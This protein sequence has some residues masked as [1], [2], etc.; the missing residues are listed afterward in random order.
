MSRRS[1][2]AVTALAAVALMLAGCATSPVAN[3]EIA[4]RQSLPD[5]WQEAQHLP[6]LI[7][8]PDPVLTELFARVAEGPDLAI[9]QSRLKEAEARLMVARAALLPNLTLTATATQSETDG[10]DQI[11]NKVGTA[12]LTVPID[13]FGANRA[14]SGASR[15]SLEAAQLEAR[16]TASLTRNTLAQLY[17]SYRA[18]QAQVAVTEASL[19]SANESLNLAKARQAA[20]LETGLGVAQA[21][22]NRDAIAARLP[23]FRQAQVASRLGLEALIGD[24]PGSLAVLLAPVAAIPQLDSRQAVRSPQEWLLARP[25]LVAAQWRLRAAGL[26]ARAALR[27]RLPSLSITAQGLTTDAG[28]GAWVASNSVAGTAAMTLFDFGRLRGLAKLAGAQAETE[29]ANYQKTVLDAMADLETQASAVRLGEVS[30]AAQAA[31]VASALDQARLARVRYTSGLSG[32]LDVLTAERAAF[33]AQSAEVTAKSEAAKAQFA[34]A[35][36]LGL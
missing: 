19:A 8:A 13:L 20:G 3:A 25:D 11:I 6:A 15:A 18:A 9:A 36:A 16:R 12:G 22:S 35:L 27:D 23:S 2:S 30:A 17:I 5:T 4:A 1:F 21:T 7:V 33:D 14:R 29:A 31:N 10:A 26:D 28:A 32:F 34:F 24:K